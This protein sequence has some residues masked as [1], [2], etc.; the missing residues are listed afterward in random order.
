VPRTK[1]PVA[2]P[3]TLAKR[4][5]TLIKDA[6]P[7]REAATVVGTIVVALSGTV[8]WGVAHFATQA[9]LFHLECRINSTIQTQ[10]VTLNTGVFDT[11]IDWRTSQIKSLAE[12]TKR[13]AD[14]TDSPALKTLLSS[15]AA[16]NGQLADEITQ[17]NG[18]R[19]GLIDK[20]KDELRTSSQQ[21]NIE[22][23]VKRAPATK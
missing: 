2:E 9:E 23:P 15:W 1:S 20:L 22:A 3:I 7:Y 21:C 14:Q 6:K 13:L 17:L 12:Q 4:I 10:L 19:A 8:A 18:Q 5:S 11:K 16:T